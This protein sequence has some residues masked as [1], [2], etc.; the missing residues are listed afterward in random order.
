MRKA[1][2]WWYLS[3]YDYRKTGSD[4]QTYFLFI[5]TTEIILFYQTIMMIMVLLKSSRKLHVL[6]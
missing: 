4:E 5:V 3:D 6:N 1:L 2:R